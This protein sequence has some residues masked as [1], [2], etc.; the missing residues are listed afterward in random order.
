MQHPRPPGSGVLPYVGEPVVRRWSWLSWRETAGGLM[1]ATHDVGARPLLI[2][3]DGRSGSGKSMAAEC[4]AREIP[5]AVVVHTDD[6]AWWED[7]LAWDHLMAAGILIPL[8]AGGA[9]SYRPPAW[10]RRH[11]PGAIDIPAGCPLVI[12]EGVGSTRVGLASLLD[13]TV[14]IQADDAEAERRGIERDG[15]TDEARSFW[16]E[17]TAQERPFLASDRPWDRAD[18]ILCGTPQLVPADHVEGAGY[19]EASGAALGRWAT[20]RGPGRPRR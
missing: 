7:F 4:I 18:L 19:E 9:V 17:W 13:V 15:G 14:W 10:D 8:R 3:V 5:G 2:G 20:G 16:S 11:R 6:V 12:T 1:S